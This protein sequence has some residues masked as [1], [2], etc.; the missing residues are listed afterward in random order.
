MHAIRTIDMRIEENEFTASGI[1]NSN[2]GI[3]FSDLGESGQELYKNDFNNIRYA[4]YTQGK[5]RLYST[6]PQSNG[7]LG[8]EFICNNHLNNN[9]DNLVSGSLWSVPEV[10]LTNGD[11]TYGVK[12]SN[13]NLG[14]PSNNLCTAND[15]IFEDYRNLSQ[16]D[17]YY[18]HEDAS[19]ATIPVQ[20]EG[21][22]MPTGIMY[23]NSCSSKLFDLPI[24][25]MGGLKKNQLEAEFSNGTSTYNSKRATLNQNLDGGDTQVLLD[26]IA[27]LTPYNKQ[28][29]RQTLN[30]ISPYV[31]DE[32]IWA[33]AGLKQNLYPHPWKLELILD[34]IHVARNTD[35]MTFLS[36]NQYPLPPGM[37]NQIQ[38]ELNAGELSGLENL[39]FEISQALTERNLSA[40]FLIREFKSDTS[41]ID[42]D[43]IRFWIS[44]KNDVLSSVNLIDLDI[45]AGLYD[46]AQ[47]RIDN[48]SSNIG[49]LSFHIK[50]ELLDVVNL[51]NRT[52]KILNNP[53]E[54]ANMTESD[55][56]F[57]IQMAKNG[58]GIAKYQSE[59]LLCFFYNECENRGVELPSLPKSAFN[60][61]NSQNESIGIENS[62]NMYPN[63]AEDWVSFEL[64]NDGSEYYFLIMDVNGR[65][66]A[67]MTTSKRIFIVETTNLSEGMY[68][69]QIINKDHEELIDIK[70][71]VIAR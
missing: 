68:V 50:Q 51:K 12:K 49:N 20:I 8:L 27:S 36:T 21:I 71:L 13:G 59:E 48:L 28:A 15:A 33:V 43:S 11:Y 23:T 38:A 34:N 26:Q 60:L 65:E 61:E 69:V 7:G 58:T 40:D 3:V 2:A 31:S 4:I 39:E 53:G 41:E 5:N 25:N 46:L 1:T 37:I 30:S 10:P 63:P 16:H 14:N 57:L 45:Q 6:T 44:Q 56:I 55:H 29:L 22:V 70:K 47:N 18:F 35:F 24:I 32:V 17:I 9:Y 62:V 54:F 67:N 52:L 64:P 42:V 19:T 66:V